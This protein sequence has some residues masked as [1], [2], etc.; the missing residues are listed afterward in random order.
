MGHSCEEAI[1]HQ[2]AAR[3]YFQEFKKTESSGFI[4]PYNE[5]LHV[6]NAFC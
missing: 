2:K 5:Y 3:Q 1:A 4:S 6:K